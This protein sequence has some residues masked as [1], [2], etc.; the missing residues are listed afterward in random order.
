MKT[1]IGMGLK[2]KKKKT[3]KQIL[4]VAKCGGILPILPLKVL[5]SMIGGAARITK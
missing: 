2:M 5:S 1:K 4:L 3:S